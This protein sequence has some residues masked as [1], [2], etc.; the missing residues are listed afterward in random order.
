MGSECLN[1][2]CLYVIMLHFNLKGME[3]RAPCKYIYIM[4]LNTPSTP[5][6]GS[7]V[8]T[9]F[10]RSHNAYQING[11]GT[12]S[13]VQVHILSLQNVHTASTPR[14]G[15][16]IKIHLFLKVVMLHIKL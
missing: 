12:Q 16:K 7:N 9:V 2:F 6:V 3:H 5:E 4:S 8:K 13:T 11:N 10:V 14:V 15:S 1:M